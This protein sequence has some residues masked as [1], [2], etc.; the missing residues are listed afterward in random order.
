MSN[1]TNKNMIST[2]IKR[3]RINTP[4]FGRS[5]WREHCLLSAVRSTL[6]RTHLLRPF[7]IKKKKKNQRTSS[8]IKKLITITTSEFSGTGSRRATATVVTIFHKVVTAV[9]HLYGSIIVI[10]CREIYITVIKHL[11]GLYH[12]P[13][14][15]STRSPLTS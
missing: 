7:W 15:F 14:F 2:L 9:G 11:P 13:E 10:T 4:T 3:K 5:V 8:T 6:Y 1:R 12:F